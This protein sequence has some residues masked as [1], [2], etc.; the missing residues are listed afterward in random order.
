MF[1]FDQYICNQARFCG[2]TG[3]DHHHHQMRFRYN[4]FIHLG[5]GMKQSILN[6]KSDQISGLSV[7]NFLT[8]RKQRLLI[9]AP[10]KRKM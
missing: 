4:K 6:A 9:I 8:N 2:S 10:I 7:E 5:V 1:L 3:S